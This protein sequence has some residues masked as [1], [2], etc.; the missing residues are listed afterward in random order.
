MGRL[1]AIDRPRAA[2]RFAATICL[3]AIGA[4]S[5][6]CGLADAGSVG[7]SHAEAAAPLPNPCGG[8]KPCYFLA[9]RLIDQRQNDEQPVVENLEKHLR[10]LRE[11]TSPSKV[12]VY[13]NPEIHI[14]IQLLTQT[15]PLTSDQQSKLDSAMAAVRSQYKTKPL[16]ICE[17]VK[18]GQFH[19]QNDGYIVY[20]MNDPGSVL[21]KL[22]NSVIKA[23][24]KQNFD[25]NA[26]QDFPDRGHYSVGSYDTSD[27]A[28]S[29]DLNTRFKPWDRNNPKQDTKNRFYMRAPY[30]TEVV[31]QSI[32]LLIRDKN[33]PGVPPFGKHYR[34]EKSYPLQ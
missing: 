31:P 15:S 14:S 28:V 25:H 30:C 22:M 10:K 3:F 18:S 34:V 24:D 29:K 17:A 26:R 8:S 16:N 19:V 20:R 5:L 27:P 12:F 23:L 32:S 2:V 13:P 7:R 9:I 4:L 33:P 6:A 11:N 21:T 1:G